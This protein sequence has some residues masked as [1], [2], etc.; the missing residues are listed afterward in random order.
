MSPEAFW[1][2]VMVLAFAGWPD[3]A[4]SAFRKLLFVS[5]ILLI[6]AL[7]VV[8]LA[9]TIRFKSPIELLND[10]MERQ[11]ARRRR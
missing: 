8:W 5:V 3:D 7:R 9:W 1:F 10:E 6:A 2:L 11:R 4:A